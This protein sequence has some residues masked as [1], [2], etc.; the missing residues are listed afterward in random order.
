MRQAK[1]SSGNHAA[2]HRGIDMKVI[3]DHKWKGFKYRN[4]VP[5]KV[6]ADQ[7][8]H[9]GEDEIDGFFCYRGYWYHL[10]DFMRDMPAELKKAGYDGFAADT[11]FSGVAVKVSNDCEEYQVALAFSA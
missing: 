2:R 9:L 7:F 11:F 10:S 4:E 6:L 8:D 5:A 1:S 3:T